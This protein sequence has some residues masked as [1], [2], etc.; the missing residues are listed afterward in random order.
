MPCDQWPQRPATIIHPQLESHSEPIL[1]NAAFA[2]YFATAARRVTETQ[3]LS[4]KQCGGQSGGEGGQSS[5]ER[6]KAHVRLT[7]EGV[8]V[9]EA[10]NKEYKSDKDLL[11]EGM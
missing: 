1:P 10:V 2:V 4:W 9:L 5:R 3:R 7:A 6:Q 11:K 8:R